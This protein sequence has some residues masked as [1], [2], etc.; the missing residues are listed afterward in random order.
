MRGRHFATGAVSDFVLEEG[1]IKAI[2]PVSSVA[3]TTD[4][5][6]WVAPGLIDIQVNGYKG[7]DFLDGNI[8]A[9]GVLEVARLL[10]E[11]GVTAF[12]PTVTT[13]SHAA[14]T[15]S[16]KAIDRACR[17]DDIAA[18]RILGIHMEGPYISPE[19]GPRGAHPPDCVRP[20]DWGEFEELQAAAGGRICLV[21]LAPEVPGALEFIHRATK[22][23]IRVSI[24]HHAATSD[25]IAAAASAGAVL[26]THLGNGAHAQMHRHHNYLWQQL[27]NDDLIAS[28]IAD[29]RHLPP[30]VVKCFYR[31]KGPSRL[32]LVSDMLSVAGLPP[33][34][35]QSMGMDIELT[36][37][38][39][40]RLAGTSYLAGSTLGMSDAV[41]LM[42]LFSGA[43]FHEVVTMAS[44]NPARL[45]GLAPER[46]ALQV[47]SRVDLTL[48]RQ[49][50]TGFYLEGTVIGGWLCHQDDSGQPTL[51]TTA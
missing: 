36:E 18:Q 35:Y 4:D 50:T 23:G 7:Y 27:A 5:D 43:P 42:M 47:G 44:Y 25:Q 32:I 37:D 31:V 46:G 21:T 1:C 8:S 24:G 15:A 30:S 12:C 13:N 38:G 29:G 9:D 34:R 19:D 14:M 16:L 33:G 22:A 17:S 28:I 51:D 6:L 3:E 40:V 49:G 20:P 45:L 2:V 10:P 41:N 39:F 26:C 11:V 48:F